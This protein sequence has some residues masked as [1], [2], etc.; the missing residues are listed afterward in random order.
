MSFSSDAELPASD[1]A[2][3]FQYTGLRLWVHSGGKYFLLPRTWS[4]TNGS[5]AALPDNDTIR[6]ESAPR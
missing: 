6:L 3:R 1:S 4:D 2:Y 5:A